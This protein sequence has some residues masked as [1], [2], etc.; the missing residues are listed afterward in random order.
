MGPIRIGCSRKEIEIRI[1]EGSPPEKNS[2]NG[3]EFRV[4][5]A[6]MMKFSGISQSGKYHSR[7]VWQSTCRAF[8]VVIVGGSHEIYA[9]RLH[10]TKVEGP[11]NSLRGIAATSP[12]AIPG[13]SSRRVIHLIFIQK[14]V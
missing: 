10:Q 1:R 13:P 11:F 8:F 3:L 6:R 7:T 4:S 5:S 9:G 2:D 12:G 14:Q